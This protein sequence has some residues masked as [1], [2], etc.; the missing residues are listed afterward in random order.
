M[1]SEWIAAPIVMKLKSFALDRTGSIAL[2]F[3][4]AFIPILVA[5]G[6]ALDYSKASNAQTQFK[7]ILDAAAL[8][9][10]R[11]STVLQT[12]GKAT[13]KEELVELVK[14]DFV[15]QVDSRPDLLAMLKDVKTE[16]TITGE[17]LTIN[18][19]YIATVNTG[20]VR[21]V[22]ITTMQMK[23]CAQA[24]TPLPSYVSIHALVD[25]SGSMGIGASTD[26]QAIMQTRLG[27]AFACHTMNWGQPIY[28]PRCDTR[29]KWAQTTNCV[30]SIGA[31]TRFDVVR[32]TLI[33]MI[34]AAQAATR[35]PSHFTFQVHK[36]SNTATQ[37]HAASSDLA[38]VK[39][40][41]Q[42]MAPDIDGAGTNLRHA[43]QQIRTSIPAGGDGRSPGSPKVYLII[44]T[45][46]V[47]GNLHYRCSIQANSTAC[48]HTGVA[49]RDGNFILNNPGFWNSTQ[50]FQ[51]IDPTV[52]TPFKSR[53]INVMTLH[54]EYYIPVNSPGLHFTQIKAMLVPEIKG[55][56]AACASSRDM[57]YSAM[58]PAEIQS[59]M[60]R[61]FRSIALKAQLTF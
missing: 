6:V 21:F 7:A 11:S 45:D 3:G 25:A 18:L 61:M 23:G 60:S 51:V 32:G 50:R 42:G 36:F 33:E 8:S 12:V 13:Q 1:F 29:N 46:G 15:A 28:S 43:L 48:L 53:G 16:G 20:F 37:I 58:T 39:R 59:A 4:L 38:S 9:G 2:G 30:H 34:E 5:A 10:V 54:T 52:C 17:A 22:G 49:G 19:C 44:L 40:A 47:E 35:W 27:C 57:A 56:L 41:V 26:D 55:R 24:V 14:R 31:K